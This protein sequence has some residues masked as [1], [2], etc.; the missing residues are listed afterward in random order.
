[1]VETKGKVRESREGWSY[2]S[3]SLTEHNAKR[4]A[5]KWDVNR[6]EKG[7]STGEKIEAGRKKKKGSTIFL[8]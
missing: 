4:E 3:R 6:L 8:S 2:R 5:Q 1:M 7:W